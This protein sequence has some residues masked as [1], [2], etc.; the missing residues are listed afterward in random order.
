M[1]QFLVISQIIISVLL[2]VLILLQQRGGGLSQVFGGQ[3]SLYRTRRGMERS[4][5]IATCV[6]ALLF[7]VTAVMSTI[8]R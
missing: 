3:S 5:L 8:F 2:I 6:L 4:I 7:F 1:S